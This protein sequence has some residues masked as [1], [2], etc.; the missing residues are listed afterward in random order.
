M[1]MHKP[2]LRV[3]RIDYL[4]IWPV[5]ESIKD[6]P[7]TDDIVFVPGHP[8]VLNKGLAEGSLDIAPSSS[9]E[10]LANAEKY[11]LMPD[12]SISA[13]TEVQSV[14]FCLPFPFD[15]LER[16]V[17]DGGNIRLSTASAASAALL[18]VLWRFYWKM[19]PVNWSCAGPGQS[20]NSGK[21]FLEIGDHAL[22][23]YFY[24]PSGLH[25]IDLA[26][27]WKKF[28][29]LP[30]VFAL[31]ILKREI[32]QDKYQIM[33]K[34]ELSLGRA[35]QSLPDRIDNLAY[36][37]PEKKFRPDKIKTYWMKMNY[38]LEAEQLAGLT[39][40]GRYLSELRMI[41]GMPV[42]DFI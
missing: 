7:I 24:P 32:S 37:Y 34:L 12:L 40:F 10:Y 22:D 36:L 41:S 28:T 15:K 20:L 11:R 3:G 25:I 9:F 21:P 33:K 6:D 23:I 2:E 5:F 16:Y 35:V 38:G 17:A 42:L 14:L 18:K 31:W 27:E 29:G 39:L 30:F 26:A 13:E 8:S 4:N 19:P 1:I